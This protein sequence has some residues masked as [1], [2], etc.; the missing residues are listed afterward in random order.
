MRKDG[1][2]VAVILT[3]MFAIFSVILLIV[4]VTFLARKYKSIY[5]RQATELDIHTLS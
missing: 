1:R 5:K 2:R 4:L 3:A